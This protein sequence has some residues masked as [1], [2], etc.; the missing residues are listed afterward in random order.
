MG[1]C[2]ECLGQQINHYYPQSF[3]WVFQTL[4]YPFLKYEWDILMR[5]YADR[6][7]KAVLGRYLSKMKLMSYRNYRYKDSEFLNQCAQKRGDACGGYDLL[8]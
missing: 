3:Q 2:K 6:G 8:L 1:I 7:A 4:D 5:R